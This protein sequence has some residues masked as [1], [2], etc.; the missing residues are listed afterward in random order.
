MNNL[1]VIIL[2]IKNVALTRFLDKESNIKPVDI[3]IITIA[4]YIN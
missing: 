2:Y 3:T 4:I 1:L